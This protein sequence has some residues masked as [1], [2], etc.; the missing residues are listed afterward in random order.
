MLG[1]LLELIQTLVVREPVDQRTQGQ[2]LSKPVL[3]V[4]EEDHRRVGEEGAVAHLEGPE[5]LSLKVQNVEF[6]FNASF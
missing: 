1:R 6:N 5:H 3:L 4:Q 2:L